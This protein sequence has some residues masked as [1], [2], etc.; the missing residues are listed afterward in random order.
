MDPCSITK[1]FLAYN[2][3]ASSG[4]ARAVPIYSFGNHD[5]RGYDVRASSTFYALAAAPT[6]TCSRPQSRS[7]SDP[8]VPACNRP[9]QYQLSDSNEALHERR[10]ATAV[11]AAPWPWGK[12]WEQVR[13]EERAWTADAVEPSPGR[14]EE[15]L[16]V[17]GAC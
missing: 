1:A 11:D 9:T 5:P 4:L 10:I 12:R 3:V 17:S 6:V 15:H 2:T 16:E 13:S 7:R 14:A 8:K